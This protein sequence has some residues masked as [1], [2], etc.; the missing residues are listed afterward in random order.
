MAQ[1]G[2]ELHLSPIE[3]A[4]VRDGDYADKGWR[5][6]IRERGLDNNNTEVFCFKNGTPG[7]IRYVYFTFDI[8]EIDDSFKIVRFHPS[9]VAL[10]QQ[11]SIFFNVYKLDPDAWETETV[12]WNTR[13]AFGELLVENTMAGGLCSVDLT[14]AV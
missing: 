14:K 4:Y 1:T 11:V 2:K 13:P 10:D 8:S 6:I 3:K 7:F 12:T 5:A 9:F